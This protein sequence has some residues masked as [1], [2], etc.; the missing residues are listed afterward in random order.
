MCVCVKEKER[1]KKEHPAKT[2]A[3]VMKCPATKKKSE[4]GLRDK[5]QKPFGRE[6]Y[7]CV[8]AHR[9]GVAP[10]PLKSY[11]EKKKTSYSCPSPSRVSL[12]YAV[13]CWISRVPYEV[14]S[15][16]PQGQKK[17]AWSQVRKR[18]ETKEATRSMEEEAAQP[19]SAV[20]KQKGQGD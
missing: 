5:E 6:I 16:N 18:K 17:S 19:T 12:P 4:C 8:N 7:S 2:M 11:A 13:P 20:Q 9:D 3:T 10:T 14:V 15:S 1:E